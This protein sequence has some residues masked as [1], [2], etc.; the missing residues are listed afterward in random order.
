MVAVA[1]RTEIPK[2]YLF[3]PSG[4]QSTTSMAFL[5]DLEL[6]LHEKPYRLSLPSDLINSTPGAFHSNAVHDV[7][8]NIV[9]TNVR[10]SED[11]LALDRNGF[12][13]FTHETGLAP[14]E[15]EDRATVRSRYFA[16]METWLKKAL[17]AKRVV[18]FDVAVRVVS[19]FSRKV[20]STRLGRFVTDIAK[21]V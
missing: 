9:V 17:G 18:I 20:S 6:Y 5:A 12:K 10:G 3:D 13:L 4:N 8:S 14:E 1:K 16:E 7:Y 11:T 21:P 2:G 19:I 15:F